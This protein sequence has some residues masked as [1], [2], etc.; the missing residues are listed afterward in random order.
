MRTLHFECTSG[1]AGD[2]LLAAMHDA[3]DP[4]PDWSEFLARLDLSGVEIH[5]SAKRVAGIVCRRLEISAPKAQPLRHLSDLLA[6][7]R[8]SSFSSR[9]R[10]R[11]EA[12]LTDLARAEAKVHGLDLDEVHFH[13][14]G[15]VDTIVDVYGFFWLLERFGPCRVTASA[16]ALGSGFVD[17]VHGRLPVPAPACVE[18]AKGLPTMSGPWEMELATPTGLALIRNAASAFGPM[19]SGIMVMAGCGAGSRA[20]DERPSMVR[21]FGLDSDQAMPAN[22]RVAVLTTMIDDLTGEDMGGAVE[23]LLEAGAL[24]AYVLTGSGKKSR[25]VMEL[26]VMAPEGMAG[27]MVRLVMRVTGSLGVRV[28]ME[29]RIIAERETFEA[30]VIVEGRAF[31]VRIKIGYGEGG[32]VLRSK[33]EFEDLRVIADQIGIG[34][35][36]VRAAVNRQLGRVD[37]AG[38]VF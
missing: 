24:D 10:E 8:Q 36:E 18:L 5:T 33:P 37:P 31:R 16:V 30:E 7:G 29:D 21:A 27:E 26:T 2:M 17:T 38:G 20:S 25:P 23:A 35:P 1:V 11:A 22:D 12:V 6:L 14:I 15:A 13:E 32:Q 4:Q 34:L 19:P 28:R 9:I 3:L